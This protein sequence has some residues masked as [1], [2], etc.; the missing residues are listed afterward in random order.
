MKY[1]DYTFSNGDKVC[2][3]LR[4]FQCLDGELKEVIS[5]ANL[6]NEISRTFYIPPGQSFT[7]QIKESRGSN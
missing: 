6:P 1:P 3:G 2:V 4:T 7:Y 5:F